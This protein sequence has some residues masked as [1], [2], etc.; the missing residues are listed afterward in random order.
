MVQNKM[1]L[2]FCAFIYNAGQCPA[3]S[4]VMNLSVPNQPADPANLVAQNLC[5]TCGLCCDG[6]L[7]KDVQLQSADDPAMLK[8]AGLPLSIPRSE[9]RI[10]RLKQPCAAL[11]VDCRCGIYAARPSCCRQFECLLL[12]SALAGRTEIPAALRI[13]RIAR[14]RAEKVRRLL[15]LLGDRDEQM[16]LSRRFRSVAK[17]I[18]EADIDEETGDLF[19]ELT[20]A[21]HDL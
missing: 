21:V 7:F 18:H 12:K 15:R 17:R 19:G 14:Q 20:L 3:P 6:T 16:P 1:S 2:Y 5:L 11:G 9:F 10:P 13:I 8:R 4:G